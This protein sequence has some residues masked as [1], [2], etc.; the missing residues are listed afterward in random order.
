MH[1]CWLAADRL[2]RS[3]GRTEGA[4]R[5][6]DRHKQILGSVLFW[7]L[8]GSAAELE[9]TALTTNGPPRAYRAEPTADGGKPC[10]TCGETGKT[11]ATRTV[12]LRATTAGANGCCRPCR[13]FSVTADPTGS[14]GGPPSPSSHTPAP[15]T[16]RLA[17]FLAPSARNHSPPLTAGRWPPIYMWGRRQPRRGRQY[18]PPPPPQQQLLPPSPP[19]PPSRHLPPPPLQLRL[20]TAD[21]CRAAG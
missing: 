3:R 1:R 15:T 12:A 9:A 18:P 8:I 2:C 16:A 10:A 7:H 14:H 11:V 5:S 6:S 19:P 20:Q 17:S 13:E 21:S 4:A